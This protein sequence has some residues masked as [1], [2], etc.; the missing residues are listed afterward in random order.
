MNKK[1]NLRIINEN[2]INRFGDDWENN[3]PSSNGIKLPKINLKTIYNIKNIIGTFTFIVTC[4]CIIVFI[5]QEIFG[6]SFTQRLTMTQFNP[7]DF[8]TWWLLITPAFLHFGLMH[9]TM[10]LFWWIFIG[11]RIERS[12]SWKPLL[13]ILLLGSVIP[14]FAQYTFFGPN[15]GGLSGVVNA[16]FGYCWTLAFINPVKFSK[17]ALP[18]GLM[19]FTV[20]WIILGLTHL[21]PGF[22]VA[23]GAHIGG[24]IMGIA[25]AIY[26]A[27]IRLR[28]K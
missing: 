1:T 5:L 3:T 19:M 24:L 20:I 12:L 25:I 4:I 27:F 10:N 22:E 8:S 28:P 2:T 26:D 16:I 17:I 21:L 13:L 6:M 7:S 14:N 15:F 18:Q 9:I 23:N 11:S